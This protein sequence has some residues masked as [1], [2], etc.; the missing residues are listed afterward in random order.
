MLCALLLFLVVACTGNR[1]AVPDGVDLVFAPFYE[2]M[3]GERIFGEPVSEAFPLASE[4]LTV[5]YF[6]NL[7][8]EYET[9]QPQSVR[10]SPLGA[11]GYE[12]LREVVPDEGVENGRSRTFPESG[13][14]VHD[15]F[16]TFY[17]TFNGQ[18]IVG[19]PISPQLLVGGVR[20]QYFENGRL[21]WRP[22]LPLEQRVQLGWLG[23]EHFDSEMAFVYR[24]FNNA[25]PVAAAEVSE[26]EIVASVES[27]VVYMG[28]EQRLFV[29]VLTLAGDQVTG[30]RVRAVMQH[31]DT[32]TE[33]DLGETNG[34]GKIVYPLD[35]D[36]VAPGQD[37]QLS[38][39]VERSGTSLGETQLTFRTWW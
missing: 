32:T 12:G 38:L 21:E 13:Q 14:S 7:R 20:T 10:I 19:W 26:A 37:V 24:E 34:E 1:E 36:A 35:L 18:Q 28:D 33:L 22:Q 23:R 4:G 11:W 29:T 17:E 39:R 27:P 3:G 31:D 15:E 16:L 6:Q 8:L 5:Q 30:V 9:G 25:A 2:A